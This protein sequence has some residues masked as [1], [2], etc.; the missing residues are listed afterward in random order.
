MRPGDLYATI[1]E[2]EFNSWLAKFDTLE[3]L[4]AA[5]HELC[6]N[7]LKQQLDGIVEDHATIVGAVHVSSNSLVRAG[8]VIQGPAIIGPNVIIDYGAKIMSGTFVGTG[9]QVL[10]GAV[11]GQS[12]L[13][14][15]TVISENCVVRN[16]ILGCRVFVNSGSLIGQRAYDSE[17]RGTFVGDDAKLEIGSIVLDGAI[18]ARG[19]TVKPGAIEVKLE[20]F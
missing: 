19:F 17:V 1:M 5:R 4:F 9:V 6:S 14:N 8:A 3:A 16:G 2:P 18:I 20:G 11:I 15:R 12:I 13:M 7:L 10:A